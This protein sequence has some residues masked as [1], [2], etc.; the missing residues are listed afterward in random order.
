MKRIKMKTLRS[1]LF[2]LMALVFAVLAVVEGLPKATKSTFTQDTAFT[3]TSSKNND[4]SYSYLV[5]G[6]IKNN[7]KRPKYLGGVVVR[8]ADLRSYTYRL[9]FDIEDDLEPGEVYELSGSTTGKAPADRVLDVSTSAADE[10][11]AIPLPEKGLQIG[12][13]F[14]IFAA[15]SLLSLALSAFFIISSIKRDHH[16][17][18]RHHHHHHHHHHKSDENSA[19]KA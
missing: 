17:H 14:I 15:L 12:K 18:H 3:V 2:L 8:I 6:S 5:E 13:G 7:S 16:R 9:D 11:A 10:D 1:I 4:G 19:E